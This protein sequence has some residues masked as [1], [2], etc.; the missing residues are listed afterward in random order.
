MISRIKNHSQ[1][2]Q[3]NF[4]YRC[5][6]PPP[7]CTF[8]FFDHRSIYY[9]TGCFIEIIII[10][11]KTKDSVLFSFSF[12]DVN[13]YFKTQLWVLKYKILANLG[14]NYVIFLMYYF[15]IIHFSD[16]RIWQ[17]WMKRELIKRE[18]FA[19][20]VAPKQVMTH[21]LHRLLHFF[22]RTQV[23]FRH[24][25]VNNEDNAK[26]IQNEYYSSPKKSSLWQSGI[27]RIRGSR[28]SCWLCLKHCDTF[29]R[30]SEKA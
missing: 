30:D 15:L 17:K 13:I 29:S 12:F 10:M 4:F 3:S 26:F 22:R 19:G 8:S 2:S 11:I 9:K 27:E 23:W 21:W 25:L 1:V 24:Y 5:S 18:K 7:R 14:E 20:W 16:K 28:L 6:Q